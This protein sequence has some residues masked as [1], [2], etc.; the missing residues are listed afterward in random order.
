MLAPTPSPVRTLLQPSCADANS[1]TLATCLWEGETQT[2]EMVADT[3]GHK[4]A[5]VTQQEE[6]RVGIRGCICFSKH[7]AILNCSVR[8]EDY[9]P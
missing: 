7:N 8:R 5:I 2:E 1:A 4:P 9:E 3:K 6:G